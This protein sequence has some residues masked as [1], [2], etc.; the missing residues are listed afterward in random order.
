MRAQELNNC[1]KIKDFFFF[2]G[3]ERKKKKKRQQSLSANFHKLT[4]KIQTTG[5]SFHPQNFKSFIFTTEVRKYLE[6]RNLESI[7]IR[8]SIK[9]TFM[10]ILNS[11]TNSVLKDG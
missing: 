7:I 8:I 1:M 11:D 10:L 9:K 5:Y 3:G 6:L 4:T 2:L